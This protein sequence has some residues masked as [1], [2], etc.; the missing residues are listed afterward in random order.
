MPLQPH[1]RHAIGFLLRHLTFGSAGGAAFGAALLALDFARLRTLIFTADQPLLWLLLMFFGL[2][3]TFGSV[4][5]GVG[6]MTI[7]RGEDG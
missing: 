1:E 7:G 3:V 2:F 6:I 5:M 4:G